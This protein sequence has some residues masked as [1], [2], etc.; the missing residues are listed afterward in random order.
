MRLTLCGTV[1]L[2]EDGSDTDNQLVPL[3]AKSL[4]LLAYLVLEPG[5]HA[6]DEL[7]GL[8]WGESSEDKSSASLRQALKQLRDAVGDVISMEHHCVAVRG[9]IHS[10]IADFRRLVEAQSERAADY[11]IPRFL[12]VLTIREAPAFQQWADSTRS[13]LLREYRRTLS[14]TARSAFAKRDW[15]RA[16][17]L[18]RRWELLDPFSDD[19]AHFHVEVLFLMGE[20]DAALAA[21]RDFCA[22]REREDDVAPGLALQALVARIEQAPSRA[23]RVAAATAAANLHP[24]PL[25]SFNAGL[26]GREREW[27]ALMHAWHALTSGRGG[28]AYIEGVA[29]IGKSRL[30]D[31]LA[32]F[33]TAQ[34]CTVLRGRAFY[35]GLDAP[36]GPVLDMLRGAI[37]APGAVGTDGAWLAEVGRIVPEIHRA[38]PSL[39]HPDRAP[40]ADGALL[41][42]GVAQLLRAVAEERRVLIVI[43][44][45]QWCD[46]DSCN[47]VHYLVHRLQDVPILWCMTM[48]LGVVDRDTPA[49][50]LARALRS[51]AA[52]ARIT[53]APL[54]Q[55]E[56]RQLIRALGQI[57]HTDGAQRLSKRVHEMTG[58]NALYVVELLKTLFVRGWLTVDPD[59]HA[60]RSTGSDSDSDDLPTSEL[61]PDVRTAIAERLAAL[62]IEQHTLLLTIAATGSGCHTSLLSYVHGISRLRAAQVCDTLVDRHLV[63]EVESHYV[64][65]HTVI[66]SVVLET[67]GVSRQREVH[68][69]IA[70]ALTDA[71]E[72]VRRIVDPGA[73]AR[74]AE[75]G[76]EHDMAHRYS[77]VASAQCVEQSAWDDALT[78]LDLATSC[79]STPEQIREA[80]DATAALLAR[81]NWRAATPRIDVSRT[82]MQ[83]ESIGRSD[84]DLPR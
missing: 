74:H 67:T 10:D 65:S 36:F 41:H 70:F 17:D 81:P 11:D 34:K 6:R 7:R 84:L 28:V 21:Y 77:L 35:A 16:L 66:A 53:L 46:A 72:S 23:T 1:Q 30:A 14:A 19:A 31:D 61:F 47:L 3:A 64:C 44:D 22:R 68:R 71:A 43:D 73:I 12:T 78:W 24:L 38:F 13:T 42:E 58:G 9:D 5:D 62:P 57:T 39:P 15:S 18:A 51:A 40:T 37:A 79:A 82:S 63:R 25:P 52:A 45:L 83:R 60:W 48:T 29:G 27:D 49:A 50:R 20:R 2:R 69:M 8:L 54:S 33:A 55:D 26:I 75:A 80:D 4:A 32:R 56:V 76:G 59:T